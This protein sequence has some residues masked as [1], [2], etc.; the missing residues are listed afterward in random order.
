[1]ARLRLRPRMS[2]TALGDAVGASKQAVYQWEM[3]DTF[4]DGKKLVAL[5]KVLKVTYSW[6]FEGIGDLPDPDH[7]D[8]S[9]YDL[10]P[11]QRAAV[12]AVI[13]TFRKQRPD[14]A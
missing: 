11:A 1:M 12:R 7:P 14:A 2:Q 4:P 9:F 10:T 6:L 3:D 5:R 8:V 13:E